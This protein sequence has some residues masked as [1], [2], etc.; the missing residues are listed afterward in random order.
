MTSEAV[1]NEGLEGG[2]LE[3]SAVDD[4]DDH[5]V[6]LPYSLGDLCL[7]RIEFKAQIVHSKFDPNAV[8]LA[9]PLVPPDIPDDVAVTVHFGRLIPENTRALYA[10]A[11]A[12]CYVRNRRLTHY[13]DLRSSFG[14][15]V[16][17]F[18]HKRRN[19]LQRN[20]RKLAAR[21]EGA[22]ECRQ[23]RGPGDVAEFHSLAREVA[24]KTYQEKLFDG[25]IPGS[26]EFVA[27]LQER[28]INDSF[29][30]FILLVGGRPISYIYL[31]I[32]EQVAELR[33]LG[34]DPEFAESSP[35]TVLMYLALEHIFAEVG[36]R[37]LNLSFGEGQ[38]K[39]V[40]GRG[41]FMQGGLYY[42]RWTA[43][44]A[45]AVYAHLATDK[46]S[47]W[48][49]SVL[50]TLGIRKTMRRVTRSVWSSGGA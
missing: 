39:K 34:Y 36:L 23:Y 5:S 22:M 9:L 29:R 44:N 50:S 24:V 2:L 12:L 38:M 16:K 3:Q 6:T 25:A 14:D 41:T 10:H 13:V 45:I 49:G 37:F 18:S 46:T 11:R 32:D 43:R 19:T 28:A 31:A 27:G 47:R 35:G 17:E 4:S 48:I 26:A 42:F 30:G 21:F 7:L 33:Y 8:P 15:Y 20:V 40:F 1:N